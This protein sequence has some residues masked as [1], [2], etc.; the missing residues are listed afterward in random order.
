MWNMLGRYRDFGLLVMRL[1]LGIL[2]LFYG[3]PKL[4]GGADE[5]SRLGEAMGYLGMHQVPMLWGILA[6]MTEFLGGVCVIFGVLFRPAC[7][8]LLVVMAVAVNMHFGR[9]DSLQTASHAIELGVVF[10]GLLF[11][12]P[13]RFS[14]IRG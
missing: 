8:A 12:G 5:W 11:I 9:G 7:L 2:M 14:F 1:G 3:W 10:F 13:G 4:L 6:A